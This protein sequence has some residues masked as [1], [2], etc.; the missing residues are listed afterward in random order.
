MQRWLWLLALGLAPCNG[1]ADDPKTPPAQKESSKTADSAKDEFA[2]IQ[3]EWQTQQMAF[4]KK[5][6]ETKSQEDKQKLFQTD[7]PKAGALAERCLALAEKWPDAPE[8]VDALFWALVNDQSD[9]TSKK[10]TEQLKKVWLEKTSLDDINKKLARNPYLPSGDLHQALLQ[11]AEKA[12]KDPKVISLLMWVNRQG[13]YDP[14]GATNAKKA[15]ELILT[16]F[17]DAKEIGQLCMGM[18]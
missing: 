8:A 7:Y 6:E 17:I 10:G 12:D 1:Y 11:R 2:A 13:Q 9:T 14:R 3:K 16:K 18:G 4:R 5:Y 15:Q